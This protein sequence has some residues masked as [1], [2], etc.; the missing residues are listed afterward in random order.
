MPPSPKVK[1]GLPS[2]AMMEIGLT[3]VLGE[4]TPFNV[5]DS[6]PG[7]RAASQQVTFRKQ[8]LIDV[9]SEQ[10]KDAALAATDDPSEDQGKR[11][12][13]VGVEEHAEETIWPPDLISILQKTMTTPCH[14][15]SKLLFEFNMSVK[16]AEKNYIILMRKFG[17]DL[18]RALHAQQGSPLQYGSEFKPVLILVLI[19]RNH[20][21]WEKMR[22]VL[23]NRSS[24]P[25]S[26]LH[27]HNRLLDIDNA[28][29]F[30][31]HKGAE[32]Q[33]ELLLKLVSNV[34]RGF[35]LPLPLDRI[36]RIPGV[37]LAPLNIQLQK[38]INDRGE[39]IPKNRMAHDQ[40]WKSIRNIRQQQS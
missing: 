8:R 16:A 9:P 7:T 19:F 33:P 32:Q 14:H 15:P 37:L 35:T 34:I 4:Y 3:A 40:S 20:P 10:V 31:N 17:G 26:P 11:F 21:S 6:D 27:N 38:T 2:M 22:T 1:F 30:G 5:D 13:H 12:C 25:L 36:Q 24:W 29:A 39:I 18:H 23:S 28:L